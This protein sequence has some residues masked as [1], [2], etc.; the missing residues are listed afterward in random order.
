MNLK[1]HLLRS[2]QKFFE[3][4]Q[5]LTLNIVWSFVKV[6]LARIVEIP[7]FGNCA[8]PKIRFTWILGQEENVMA[9]N[10]LVL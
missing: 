7:L 8:A 2:E 3:N 5:V 6:N 4:Y 10:Y 9:D 1:H